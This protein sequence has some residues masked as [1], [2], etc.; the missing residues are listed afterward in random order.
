MTTDI[1]RK[2][3]STINEHKMLKAG[4]SVLACVSGGADSVALLYLLLEAREELS[5][6]NVYACHFNHGIRGASSDSDEQFVVSLCER[7]GVKLVCESGHMA[8][9][10]APRGLSTEAWAR[11]ERYDF[12]CRTAA[13]LG[14]IA[15]TAHNQNDVA[16]TVLLNLA[17]GAGLEGAGGIPPV[18]EGFIRPLIDINR[19]EIEAYLSSIG[20]D[21]VTDETNL[22]DDYS[23]N[24]VRHIVLPALKT[25]NAAAVRNIARFAARARQ[26]DA[27]LELLADRAIEQAK[28]GDDSYYV[29]PI[30]A[31]DE[32]VRSLAIKK[33]LEHHR[34]DV[35]ENSIA[36][37]LKVL[38]GESL[39]LQLSKDCYLVREKDSIKF[40]ER[41]EPVPPCAPMPL[42]E[43]ENLFCGQVL[44]IEFFSGNKSG[45]QNVHN[46]DLINAADYAKIKGKLH[47]R[48]R[49]E[50]DIFTGAAR[51]HT[52]SLKKLFN[53]RGIPAWQRNAVPV[54]CD[55]E[56]IVFVGGEGVALRCALTEQQTQIIYFG[57]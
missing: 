25:V 55:D 11:S 3:V 8:S 28:N 9:R 41:R 34:R 30:A 2:F 5:L 38:S 50:G 21:F 23:R 16:E 39:G 35:G 52:K 42:K 7:L 19:D 33:L 13:K 26:T 6:E 56:G 4:D 54:V 48:S 43:G 51:K 31:L 47:V 22:S 49:C 29:S 12:F 27:Y 37:A 17:R 32:P 46:Y 53:E 45:F 10:R 15:A 18:R 1:G 36:P 40:T 14:A 20:A 44:K 57:L 24:R